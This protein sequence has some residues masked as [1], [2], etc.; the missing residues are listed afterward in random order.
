MAKGKRL[1]TVSDLLTKENIR[2]AIDLFL[3]NGVE[4]A[5]GTVIVWKDRNGDVYASTAGF[6]DHDEAMGV[7][8][9]G[10]RLLED[11]ISNKN[12]DQS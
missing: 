12:Q 3:K 6:D 1:T 8:M 9:R 4:R 10:K 11:Y 2:D 5:K 7:L